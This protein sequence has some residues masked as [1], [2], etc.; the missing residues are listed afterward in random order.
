MVSCCYFLYFIFYSKLIS[1]FSI[2]R[3]N[4]EFLD[5]LL[6]DRPN[7]NSNDLIK[8]ALNVSL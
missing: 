8:I 7:L 6:Q 1:Y 5:D 3:L 4:N 2:R